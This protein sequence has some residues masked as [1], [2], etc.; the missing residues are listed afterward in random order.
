MVEKE[1]VRRYVVGRQPEAPVYWLDLMADALHPQMP[2]QVIQ[3]DLFEEAEWKLAA[4]LPPAV[5]D[6]FRTLVVVGKVCEEIVRVARVR[7]I[8]L[9][10]LGDHRRS[11]LTGLFRKNLAAQVGRRAAIPVITIWN[12]GH[13]ISDQPWVSDSLLWGWPSE[14]HTHPQGRRGLDAQLSH[15]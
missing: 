5:N 15:P 11:G 12:S 4:L 3:H 9:I 14:S 6:R 2:L 10:M 1:P 13:V 7:E 8:D